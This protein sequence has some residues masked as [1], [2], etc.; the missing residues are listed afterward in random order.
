MSVEFKLSQC[1]S[2]YQMQISVKK[3]GLLKLFIIFIVKDINPL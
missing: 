3:K 2:N 1:V